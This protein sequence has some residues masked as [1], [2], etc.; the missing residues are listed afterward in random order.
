[1]ATARD[2]RVPRR[3]R[4][5]APQPS[6][7]LSLS[8]SAFFRPFV[9]LFTPPSFL[10][11]R[12]DFPDVDS[13]YIINSFRDPLSP[14][15]REFSPRKLDRITIHPLLPSNTRRSRFDSAAN[16]AASRGIDKYIPAPIQLPVARS[17][18]VEMDRDMDRGGGGRRMEFFRRKSVT[19]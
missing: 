9:N 12:A 13:R 10:H 4:G 15:R 19:N 1:M 11:L 16:V 17:K 6:L 5:N 3:T 7:S 18:R 2:T 8:S 14:L